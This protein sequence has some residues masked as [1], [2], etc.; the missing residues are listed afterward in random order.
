VESIASSS[1]VFALPE[2][3][4]SILSF[5]DVFAWKDDP[6][7]KFDHMMRISKTDGIGITLGNKTFS[8]FRIIS[9]NNEETV[10]NYQF[11]MK[12]STLNNLK[13][14]INKIENQLIPKN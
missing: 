6:T 8:F 7:E 12:F 3:N 14:A 4:K 10:S 2:T 9:K 5:D 1:K 13:L 11:T